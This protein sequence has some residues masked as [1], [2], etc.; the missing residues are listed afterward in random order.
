[1]PV[2]ADAELLQTLLKLLRRALTAA[3]RD[4]DAAD[5]KPAAFKCVDQA[6]GVVVIRDA[7][8]AAA[9][10]ALDV[11]RGD[12]D[13]DL[14]VPAHFHEHAHLAVRLKARQHARGVIIVEQLA[15]KFQIQLA[16][17]M[18]DSLADLLR[19]QPYVLCVVKS[20]IPHH[21]LPFVTINRFI[22]Q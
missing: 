11:V 13:D 20:N 2:D 16:A 18:R 17:E 9:L 4:D 19:L 6:Q 10:V 22:L 3:V 15:A 1:M 21:S 5:E 12:G 8:I 7:E 14:R